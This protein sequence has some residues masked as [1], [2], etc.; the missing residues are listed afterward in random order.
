M[1]S[2]MAILLQGMDAQQLG[3]TDSKN[4][5][6]YQALTRSCRCQWSALNFMQQSAYLFTAINIDSE[7]K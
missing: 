1:P 7:L 3:F 2:A 5:I 6:H 4:Q